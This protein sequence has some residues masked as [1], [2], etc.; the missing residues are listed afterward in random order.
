M[1][2]IGFIFLFGT[3]LNL[4][5]GC[6]GTGGMAQESVQADVNR[7]CDEYEGYPDCYPDHP[8]LA[9]SGVR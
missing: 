2:A 4:L 8:L 1:R 7:H 3:A 5:T 6:T 9:S